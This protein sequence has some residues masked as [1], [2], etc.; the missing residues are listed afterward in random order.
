[1]PR[2][3]AARLASAL[4]VRSQTAISQ[5]DRAL[6]DYARLV[7]QAGATPLEGEIDT[8]QV[9]SGTFADARIAESNVTQHEA[10]LAITEIQITDLGD[11]LEPSGVQTTIGSAGAA[12]ALPANPTGYVLLTID[13]ATRAVPYYDP[14]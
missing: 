12:A 2:D 3:L 4:N 1:M 5:I 13:G 10:A 8:S 7:P 11:Y 6:S 14:S 9:T